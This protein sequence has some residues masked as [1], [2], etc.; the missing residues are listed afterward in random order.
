VCTGLIALTFALVAQPAQADTRIVKGGESRLSVS[1]VNFVKLLNDGMQM[2]AI[3]PA[4]LEFGTS[5]A[6]VLPVNTTGVADAVLETAAVPH[7]G[8]IRM[9]KASINQT[10]DATNITVSCVNAGTIAVAGC[11]VLNTAN[12]LLP[13]ELAEI[14]EFEFDDP[15]GGKLTVTGFARITA[16]TALVLNTLFETNVFEAGMELGTWKSEFT[17]LL[18]WPGL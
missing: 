3:P 14:Q 12:N 15:N 1:L 18:P 6:A 17:Y 8:G 11:R 7:Q 2:T 16:A 4:R 9:S 13:N 10:I 5:P